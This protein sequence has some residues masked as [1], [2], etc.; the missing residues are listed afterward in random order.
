MV[1][2]AFS[3]NRVYGPYFFKEN[4]NWINYLELL[5]KF[6]WPKFNK[7]DEKEKYY[8][9]Q[10]G[11]PPHRKKEAQEWLKSKFGDKFLDSS[12]WPPRSPDL[13]P[14]DFSLWGIIKEK[15]YNPK[16]ETIDELSEKIKREIEI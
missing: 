13:N 11:A 3:S 16:P 15:V 4:V 2:C 8:F 9:Q 1:W 14:C 10:D 7:L 6:F 12:I 5:K